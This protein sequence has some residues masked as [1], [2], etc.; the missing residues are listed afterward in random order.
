MAKLIGDSGEVNFTPRT[1]AQLRAS[2]F[3]SKKG[4]DDLEIRVTAAEAD[5]DALQ[6]ADTF[7]P[8]GNYLATNSNAGS[9]VIGQVVYPPTNTHVD[10][11]RANAL[12]TSKSIGL[13]AATAIASGAIGMIQTTGILTATTAQWDAVT[14]GSGGLTVNAIYYL[15]AATAGRLTT[16]APTT[17]GQWVGQ[18]GLA[19][20]ATKLKLDIQQT[21]LL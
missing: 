19:L 12:T 16:T 8:E 2:L 5:I 14:G 21:I 3:A 11:A 15:S 17:A 1:E 9:I 13:V 7:R 10:L 6:L 18:M 20:S 4:T